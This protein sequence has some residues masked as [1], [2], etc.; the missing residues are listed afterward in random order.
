M[1]P[2]SQSPNGGRDPH[3]SSPIPQHPP[4][5][6]LGR[7]NPVCLL[8]EAHLSQLTDQ[9][10][11]AELSTLPTEPALPIS[12]T[13]EHFQDRAPGT[14][15]LNSRSLLHSGDQAPRIALALHTQP[16][17]SKG[18]SPRGISEK[19]CSERC[20]ATWR[21][22]LALWTHACAKTSSFG[23]LLGEIDGADISGTEPETKRCSAL[24]GSEDPFQDLSLGIRPSGPVSRSMPYPNQPTCSLCAKWGIRAPATWVVVGGQ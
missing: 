12:V 11:N 24:W 13:G 10:I 22:V 9:H 17:T 14:L 7:L 5:R 19:C 23:A 4:V 18:E 3:T 8:T 1:P 20:L 2:S 16:L 15:S 21:W 6:L